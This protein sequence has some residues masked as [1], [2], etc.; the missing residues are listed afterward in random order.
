MWISVCVRSTGGSLESTAGGPAVFEGGMNT[1]NYCLDQWHCR[2]A[3]VCVCATLVRGNKDKK[4]GC[5]SL[6]LSLFINAV[7]VSW[8][9][10]K[11]QFLNSGAATP[12]GVIWDADIVDY[13]FRYIFISVSFDTVTSAVEFTASYV[14]L[15]SLVL[16]SQGMADTPTS[17]H[18]LWWNCN[19]LKRCCVSSTVMMWNYVKAK[20][21]IRTISAHRGG[22]VLLA[23]WTSVW[24][25]VLIL[26]N[27]KS[28]LSV[29]VKQRRASR[30]GLNK[31]S[32]KDC[33]SLNCHLK[34]VP[35]V[36]RMLN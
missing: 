11:S 19:L 33:N 4:T 9:A 13:V 6:S 14:A 25:H 15:T 10:V 12:H 20:R 5:D 30:C 24:I 28:E 27:S 16:T 3:S 36:P 35:N 1:A 22:R 26:N 2:L 31:Y 34:L 17:W 29:R 8:M 23:I 32:I 18:A 7:C 21:K